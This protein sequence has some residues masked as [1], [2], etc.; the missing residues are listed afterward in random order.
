MKK[1][2][3]KLI[4]RICASAILL[5]VLSVIRQHMTIPSPVWVALFAIPYLISGWDVLF[6]AFR[7]IIRGQVFD[8][9]FL[10]C[11]AT[12]GAFCIGEYPEAVFVMIFYQAGELFQNIAVGKSRRSISDLMDLSPETAEVFRNGE[13]ITVSP[14]DVQLGE[15]IFVRPG[16]KVP[17]DGKVAIGESELNTSALTGESLPRSIRPG[18]TVSSGCINV[19]SPI[20]LQTTALYE[21]STVAKILELVENASE[22]KAKTERFISRFAAYY[23]PCVVAIAALIAVIPGIITGNF[24]EWLHRALIM[25]VISCP[26]ALVISVPLSYFGGIGAA[27]KRGILVKGSNYLEALAHANTVVFDKTG[28]LTKGGFEI[29]S[30]IPYTDTVNQD[31]LF[32]IAATL[33][34]SS[35][36]PIALSITESY[37]RRFPGK[38]IN[39]LTELKEHPGMGVSAIIDQKKIAIGNRKLMS[40]LGINTPEID[41]SDSVLFVSENTDLLGYLTIGD[42][43]KTES[44]MAVK[45]IKELGISKTVLLTGDIPRVANTVAKEL[46]I[47]DVHASL[48]PEDKVAIVSSFCETQKANSKVVFV[49]DGINDAPV[50]MRSD[51]GIAMGALG[52]DAAIEA[53]DVVLMDD[54]PLKVAEAIRISRKTNRIVVQ[55][56][57]FALVIKVGFLALGAFGLANLWEAVFADVGVSVLAILNAMRALTAAAPRQ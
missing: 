31:R 56:I 35:T 14:D 51:I 36:H 19:T 28:T 20:H 43:I 45:K 53:A 1:K 13:L 37:S 49:G 34:A 7:N 41:T 22:S 32:E 10:M 21:D 38:P 47:D 25:L 29:K 12:V 46:G 44:A 50:L 17:I 3:Y 26:C 30:I 42:A 15:T 5:G 39:T 11:I 40:S 6:S 54:N 4:A 8:E 16:E 18:D 23:T 24:A 27:G 48:Y 52:S 2:H 33:E 57:V 9:N 55:N